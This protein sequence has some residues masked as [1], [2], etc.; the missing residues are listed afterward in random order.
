[1][2]AIAGGIHGGSGTGKSGI[3]IGLQRRQWNCQRRLDGAG[4]GAKCSEAGSGAGGSSL[5]LSIGFGGPDVQPGK[6]GFGFGKAFTECLGRGFQKCVQ[7]FGLGDGIGGRAAQGGRRRFG[8]SANHRQPGA[9]CLQRAGSAVERVPVL[10]ER[11]G[12]GFDPIADL[13][14]P[15]FQRRHAG[16]AML[17]L[18]IGEGSL[19]DEQAGAGGAI[20]AAVAKLQ[21][22]QPDHGQRR[23]QQQH[24]RR[25]IGNTGQCRGQG[26]ARQRSEQPGRCRDQPGQGG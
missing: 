20:G 1:M 13:R 5:G 7:A 16:G 19:F 26:V 6:Y 21:R 3:G 8:V 17:Q 23:R 2:D 25:R 18:A 12:D 11:T 22:H 4:S 15:I 10:G 9:A 14:Q 24:R